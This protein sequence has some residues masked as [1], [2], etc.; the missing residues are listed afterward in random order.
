MELLKLKIKNLVEELNEHSRKYYVLD[1][2]SISDYEYDMLYRELEEM[3]EKYP[4]LILPY[5][6]TQRVGDT[7][8]SGFEKVRHEVQMQ[9]L[10]D[11]FDFDELKAF[12]KR[13]A[14]ALDKSYSYVAEL[15]IDGL[16]VSLEYE[17]GLFVRGSTRGDGIVGEDITQNL[18]TINSIPMKLKE[19]VTIEVRGEVFM[20]KSEFLKINTLREEEGEPIFA[21]PRNAAAGS[22]RQLDSKITAKR[23]LDIFIFNVQ[24]A[25]V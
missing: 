8:L 3:E 24:K 7:V 1:N 13:V 2:P 9:S 25:D 19:P 14:D 20:P 17:N 22:L 16:S 10:N 12:D 6:P 4:D 11:V 23:N 18:K 5:S 15:K 21:N